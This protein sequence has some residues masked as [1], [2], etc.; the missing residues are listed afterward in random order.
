MPDLKK[1]DAET[2]DAA[3]DLVIDRVLNAPRAALWRCWAE[4]KLLEQWFCPKPWF[5]TDAKLD[6]RPGGE[7]SFVM[8]G[9][10]GERFPNIGV[11]LAVEPMTRIVTTDA[12]TPG[13]RPSGRAFMVAETIFADA[14]AGKTRYVA[15]ARHWTDE[16]RAEHEAMGF[17]EGWGKAADQLEALA[18]TL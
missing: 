6:L 14:D 16:A 18:R 1:P 7:C 15:T 11:F 13:W 8:N 5:V 3:N 2:P 9:P 10:D 12:L 17:H 4:P